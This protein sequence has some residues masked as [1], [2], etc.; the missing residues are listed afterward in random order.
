[1]AF[2]QPFLTVLA[3]S[4]VSAACRIRPFS[5]IVTKF[6]RAKERYEGCSSRLK[7]R[8]PQAGSHGATHKALDLSTS[9]GVD[10]AV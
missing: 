3:L 6:R 5:A 8:S 9:S 7:V 2:G 1:M 4:F 10:L